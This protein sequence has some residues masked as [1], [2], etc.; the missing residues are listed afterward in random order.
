MQI[1]TKRLIIREFT[2]NDLDVFASLVAHPEVMRFSLAGPLSRE[3]AKEYLQKRILDHYAKYGFGLWALIRLEGRQ[4]LGFAG[5]IQQTVDKE[6]IVELGYRLDPEWWGMGFATEAGEAICRYA[7]EQLKLNRLISVIE[8]KNV[9]SL[10]VA[11]RLGMR[12]WKETLF[13]GLKASIYLLE[14]KK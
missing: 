10:R 11:E 12:L 1:Q 7:F 5:L 13:H 2:E 6:E 4:F 14:N 9:Q 3:K 8:P